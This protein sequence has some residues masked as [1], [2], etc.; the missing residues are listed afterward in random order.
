MPPPLLAAAR[1]TEDGGPEREDM[2]ERTEEE[3]ERDMGESPSTLFWKGGRRR[4]RD[5]N[6]IS[7]E[8]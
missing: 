8:T 4:K 2:W 3:E 5:R 7:A 6:Q 1:E